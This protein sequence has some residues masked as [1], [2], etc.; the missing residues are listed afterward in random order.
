[1]YRKKIEFRP[2]ENLEQVVHSLDVTPHYPD[3]MCAV[4]SSPSQLLYWDKDSGKI[5]L[6]DCSTTPP[7]PQGEIPIVYDGKEDV[8]DMCTSRDLLVVARGVDGVFAYKLDGGELKWDILGEL[9][10]MHRDM[11]AVGVTA[12]DNGHLFMCDE[13]NRCVHVLSA[14]DGAH[15]GVVVREWEEVSF[16]PQKVIYHRKSASVILAHEV[17]EM[18]QL[19]VFSRKVPSCSS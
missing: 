11:S 13:N 15:L 8:S 17:H 7:T 1:M 16:R 14:R 3:Y 2:V 5:H 4:T 10:G 12:D 6:V 19:S 18:Y 9:P